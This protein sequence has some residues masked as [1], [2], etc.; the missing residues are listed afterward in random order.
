MYTN[1]QL[2]LL[3]DMPF[4]AFV[5]DEQGK[6]LWCNKFWLNLAGIK[7]LDAVIGKTDR[8]L[9]WSD[10]AEQQHKIDQEVLTKGKPISQQMNVSVSGRDPF[11][12]NYCKFPGVLDGKKCIF[13]VSVLTK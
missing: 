6:Y 8:D 9:I 12:S 7:S 11:I 5:K 2:E 3:S 4:A 13:G 10:Y 1:K